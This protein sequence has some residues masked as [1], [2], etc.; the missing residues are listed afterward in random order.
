MT[1]LSK[2]KKIC[3]TLV[4]ALNTEDWKAYACGLNLQT[5]IVDAYEI[6]KSWLLW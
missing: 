5:P 1:E 3:S 2:Q 6:I 4:F